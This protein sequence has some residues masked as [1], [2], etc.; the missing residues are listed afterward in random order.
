MTYQNYFKM[1]KSQILNEPENFNVFYQDKLVTAML[2]KNP[3]TLGHI[4]IFPNNETVD[5]ETFLHLFDVSNACATMIFE[6]L[7]LHGTNIIIHDGPNSDSPIEEYCFEVIG[8]TNNDGLNLL[9]EPK[10]ADNLKE[11]AQKIKDKTFFID[12]EKN[13]KNPDS[14]NKEENIINSSEENYMIKHLR[15]FP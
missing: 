10:K 12:K 3:C 8:R 2:S 11:V 1:D 9:W 4:I 5:Q 7:N 13:S 6:T 14:E 15:H